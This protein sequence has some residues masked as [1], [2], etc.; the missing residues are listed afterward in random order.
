MAVNRHFRRRRTVVFRGGRRARTRSH[1][2][3][4]ERKPIWTI[5]KGLSAIRAHL[6]DLSRYAGDEV[7]ALTSAI[8]EREEIPTEQIVL[9]EILDVLGLYLSAS[10]GPGGEFVYS[11][12]ALAAQGIDIGRAYPPL[13]TWVRISIRAAQ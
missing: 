9:G 8:S 1:S 4:V 7:T 12:A 13:G 3:I 5:A 11:A 6:A 2:L 10:G